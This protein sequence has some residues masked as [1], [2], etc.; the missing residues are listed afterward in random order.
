MT[1][2]DHQA[3]YYPIRV[4]AAETGVNAITLR[5]WERR[6]GLIT[7]KRTAKGHRLYT[8]QDI[9]LI[10]QVVSLLDRG[11]PIS[12]AQAMLANGDALNLAERSQSDS[13]SQWQHYREQLHTAVQE[14]NDEKLNNIF[15][16]VCQFFPVDVA[17]RFLFMPFYQQLRLQESL[18]LGSARLNF[19]SAFLQARMAWRIADHA[20]PSTKST[21]ILVTN[22]TQNVDIQPLLLSIL[23]QQ[24]DMGITRLAD[25]VTPPG[26]IELLKEGARWSAALVQVEDSPS[27][28]RISQLKSVA[29]ET[30]YPVFTTGQNIDLNPSL[31]QAGLIPL[32]D[33]LQQA[34]LTI[35][36]LVT[37]ST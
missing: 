23:L 22:S 4:V 30:G 7:P 16:E 11:L 1:G 5:A 24:L 2:S 27:Q 35:R 19:Y 12:Q 3:A 18:S 37:S 31:R 6:Y 10:K 28:Q 17:I 21:R 14:F 32:G 33:D 36:D 25:I 26:I 15:E 9:Q 8:E 29:L 13:A 34:A 20:R